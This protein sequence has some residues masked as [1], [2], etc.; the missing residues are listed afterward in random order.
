MDCTQ[1]LELRRHC[2][3]NPGIRPNAALLFAEI[4]DYH[5]LDKGCVARDTTLADRLGC[6]PRAIRSWRKELVSAGYVEQTTNGRHRVLKPT[7]P[8]GFEPSGVH[9]TNRN[10][11]STSRNERSTDRNIRSKGRNE[12]SKQTGT[13]VPT[14][15]DNIHPE[16]RE[17][18]G[19][20]VREDDPP[21]VKAFV[22]GTGRR[23]QAYERDRILNHVDGAFDL[24]EKE[25][26]KARDNVGGNPKR[27]RLGYLLAE[28]D[29]AVKRQKRKKQN[30][31]TFSGFGS[32]MTDFSALVRKEQ[33]AAHA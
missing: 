29:K 10:E 31:T 15:R 13:N 19:A 17:R 11:R 23:P 22:R 33:E 20:R 3:R 7:S 27:V 8:P 12:R 30:T 32:G 1:L 4:C 9:N 6:T 16:G 28:Y 18:A 25:C 2:R 14:Q 5:M 26:Q 21:A 24:F